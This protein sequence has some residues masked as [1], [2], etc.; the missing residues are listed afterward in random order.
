MGRIYTCLAEQHDLRLVL[1]AGLICALGAHAS[2]SLLHHLRRTEGAHRHWWLLA[3]AITIG[4]AVW[5]THFI[6]MLAYAPGNGIGYHLGQTLLSLLVAVFGLGLAF[7][8]AQHR[9]H[10]ANHVAGGVLAGLA[11]GGMHYLGMQAFEAAGAILWLPEMVAASI[12]LGCVLAAAALRLGLAANTMRARLAG[13]TLLTLAICSLHFTGMAAMILLRDPGSA[14]AEGAI[15]AAWLAIGVGFGCVLVLLL[16]LAGVALDRRDM[17]RQGEEMQRMRHLADA[18]VE[19]LLVCQGDVIVT[20]N[21]SFAAIIGH[22]SATLVGRRLQDMLPDAALVAALLQQEGALEGMLVAA[23]GSRIPVELVSRGISYGGKPHR[24][25]ACRDLRDRQQAEERIRFLAHH[26]PLTELPN[27][28]SFNDQLDRAIA[29]RSRTAQPFA[30]LALD[31]DRFKIVNDTLGHGIGDGLLRQVAER[32]RGA[33]RQGDMVAR[34]GGDEFAVLQ[35]EAH[36]PDAAVALAD[37]LVQQLSLPYAV[38]GHAIDI[39]TSIGIAL[40]PGDGGEAATLLRNADLALYR[41]KVDGRGT[42]RCFEAEMDARMQRRRM[43]ELELRRALEADQFTLHYQ[44]LFGVGSNAITGFEALLR[45]RHPQRGMVPPSEFIPLAEETGLIVPIG[46]W[47]LREACKEAANW[48][49]HIAVAVNLSPVQFRSARLPAMVR[50]AL[51]EARLA[52][53]RLELEITESVLLHDSATTLAL[54]HEL[55]ALGI[56]VSMDDFGTGY[57]SLSYL[58]SFPFDKIKIDRSFITDVM[59]DSDS[60]AIVRAI[61]SLGQS[62][63]MQTTVEGV[64]TA[65]QFAHV[66]A[67]GCDQVQGYLVGR[68]VP[69]EEARAL[70]QGEEDDKAAA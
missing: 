56:R 3:S 62:L 15:P 63:G 50:E 25:I 41:A 32:L 53:Q 18:A 58:R 39:G 29:L 14:V 51:A 64:E 61:I 37:R 46:E 54:L 10:A 4:V 13:T 35:L 26:D 45:W 23:D 48:P 5:A 7:A 19:G 43:L 16:S 6:A 67:E 65:A 22:E 38:D 11:I 20:A 59:T 55:R 47:V 66:V 68:P 36:Q 30:V 8:V 2:F 44:P 33:L 21:S 42:H 69:Q 28:A 57:S 60:A 1:F 17:Q 9:R 49:V 24:I 12:A 52:P 31:L 34:L 27:R 70:L 40:F